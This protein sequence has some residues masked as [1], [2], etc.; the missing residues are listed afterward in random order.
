MSNVDWGHWI[1]VNNIDSIPDDALGFVY[2]ITEKDTNKFYIGCKQLYRTV[3]RPPLKGKKNKRHSV[4]D[5]DWRTYCSS[6]GM[7]GE[8]IQTDES[9]YIFELLSFH[10]SKSTLKIAEAKIIIENIYD[11]RCYNKVV[12]LRVN[13]SSLMKN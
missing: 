9:K 5:S 12:N 2:K 6:S 8:A 10:P 11:K 13:V 1:P 7:I 4:K 3:K